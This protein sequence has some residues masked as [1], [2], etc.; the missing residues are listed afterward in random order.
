MLLHGVDF[1]M[2]EIFCLL[3]FWRSIG[4]W[5]AVSNGKKASVGAANWKKL[6][7]PCYVALFFRC[8]RED[9]RTPNEPTFAANLLG[10]T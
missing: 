8:Y 6:L 7:F 4:D 9:C 1:R 3:S 5:E 2:Q 10:F